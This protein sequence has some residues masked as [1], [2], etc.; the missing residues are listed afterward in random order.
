MA[1]EKQ[2]N[3]GIKLKAEPFPSEAHNITSFITTNKEQNKQT[4][5]TNNHKDRR[6]KIDELFMC[7]STDCDE[8]DIKD[9]IIPLTMQFGTN[10]FYVGTGTIIHI[11]KNT[12]YILTCAHNLMTFHPYKNETY[13]TKSVWLKFQNK[14]IPATKF[15]TYPRYNRNNKLGN[16]IAIIECKIRKPFM[17][18]Q[19]F[20]ILKSL[21]NSSDLNM[22]NQTDWKTNIINAD[23]TS[24]GLLLV[25]TVTSAAYNVVIKKTNSN[26]NK[27]SP[28]AQMKCMFK[29]EIYGYPGEKNGQLWGM[30]GDIII[31]NEQ[32]LIS[33]N[34]IDTTGGQSG[35]PIFV[36]G[37]IVGIHTNGDYLGVKENYGAMLT[38]Q[39]IQWIYDVMPCQVGLHPK[40]Y[41]NKK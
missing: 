16:D 22:T 35:A 18:Y 28:K 40:Y 33:Y 32:Y 14:D 13:Y 34:T 30:N 2:K 1:E 36:N 23:A 15:Y 26:K 9:Y 39:R 20:P 29:G 4:I 25:K 21:Q 37:K 41:R 7:I 3:I 8:I 17:F 11:I 24:V 5:L 10:K 6:N 31:L 27:N 19:I 12:L 38:K